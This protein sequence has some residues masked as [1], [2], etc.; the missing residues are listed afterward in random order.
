MIKNRA[1]LQAKLHY[2]KTCQPTGETES[3]EL[4]SPNL[5]SFEHSLILEEEFKPQNFVHDKLEVVDLRTM[6][7][8]KMEQKSL[9]FRNNSIESKASMTEFSASG[10]LSNSIIDKSSQRRPF[11]NGSICSNDL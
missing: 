9:L 5:P 7:F 4:L 2:L 8:G 10:L 11:S 3:D 6:S 1:R